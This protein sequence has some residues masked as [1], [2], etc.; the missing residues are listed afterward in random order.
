MRLKQNLFTK[1]KLLKHL[2]RLDLWQQQGYTYPI[3]ADFDLTNKCNNKCP[4]CCSVKIER[5]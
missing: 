1:N 5:I 4:K 3:L 2:D